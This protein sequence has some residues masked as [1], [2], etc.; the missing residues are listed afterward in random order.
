MLF[1]A[2]HALKCKNFMFLRVFESFCTQVQKLFILK[3]FCSYQDIKITILSK[4]MKIL[5]VS[6]STSAMFDKKQDKTYNKHKETTGC[7]RPVLLKILSQ[8]ETVLPLGGFFHAVIT[9]DT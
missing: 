3:S 5:H 1:D 6:R 2:L 7:G 9:Y 4:Y 8:K